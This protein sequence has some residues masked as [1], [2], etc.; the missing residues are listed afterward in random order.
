M[1]SNQ[2]GGNERRK[3]NGRNFRRSIPRRKIKLKS[4]H[5][6]LVSPGFELTVEEEISL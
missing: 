6:I 1:R 3:G 5:E 2:Q 4:R